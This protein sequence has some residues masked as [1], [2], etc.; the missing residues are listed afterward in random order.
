MKIKFRG[1]GYKIFSLT[2]LIVLITI[3]LFIGNVVFAFSSLMSERKAEV[4]EMVIQAADTIDGDKHVKAVASGSMSSTEYIDLKQEMV[5]F[6]TDKNVTYFYTVYM[7]DNETYFGVDAA[8]TDFEELGAEGFMDEH[9]P[10][11]FKGEAVVT[12]SLD[13][14]NLLSAYAPIK[15]SKGNVVGVAGLDMDFSSFVEVNN[16]I[17]RDSIVLAVVIMLLSMI[18]SFLFSQGITKRVRKIRNS[19]NK[20]S[21]G[22]LT[23][24]L[25]MKGRDEFKQI[26]DDLNR[27][28]TRTSEVL[29]DVKSTSSHV[30]EY[31]QTLSAVSQEMAAA[32]EDV[33]QTIN[34]MADGINSQSE[35]IIAALDILKEFGGSI[36]NAQ[37]SIQNINGEVDNVNQKADQSSAQLYQ[38]ES[39]IKDVNISFE[40][41]RNRIG[42]LEGNISRI[43]EITDL[44]NSIAD[45]TNLLALNAAI[46]AARAGEA[47]KGF[48]VVADEIRK[49]AEQSKQS[50]FSINGILDNIIVDSSQV[51][52]TSDSMNVK[53]NNQI[54]TVRESIESFR[55]II[56]SIE[57]MLPKFYAVNS[58]MLNVDR[59]KDIIIKKIDTVSSVAKGLS[60]SAEDISASMEEMSASSQN[61]AETA[62]DLNNITI[63]LVQ[64]VEQFHIK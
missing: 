20:M 22:D 47:G 38:L 52:K 9:L 26:S 25:V 1:L 28:T 23:E 60:S 32:S 53:L 33:A 43:S 19:L 31:S 54:G 39:S 34:N 24:E 61:V 41:V 27:L 51:L 15:D 59:Q 64:A 55:S 62:Q 63:T 37:Q 44:I 57:A 48:S 4:L 5:N 40:Q 6:K 8:F 10:S 17:I 42:S 30:S 21:E 2:S 11:A 36:E 49:L 13:E 18:S 7:K 50:S 46:E 16:R 12:A 29:N 3:L 14:D 56:N 35:E 45:Q 58:D